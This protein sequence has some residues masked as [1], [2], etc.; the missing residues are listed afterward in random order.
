MVEWLKTAQAFGNDEKVIEC[1]A[2]Q[3]FSQCLAEEAELWTQDRLD[4]PSV[5]KAAELAEGYA[6]QRGH[7]KDRS[8]GNKDGSG[9]RKGFTVSCTERS[10]T[11]KMKL[12]E[13]D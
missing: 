4:E 12:T 1:I 9:D 2:L 10:R 11:H 8:D 3:Q 13:K 7:K 5:Q 6:T